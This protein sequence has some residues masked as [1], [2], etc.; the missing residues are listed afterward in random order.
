[1][2]GSLRIINKRYYVVLSYKSPVT[3]KWCTTTRSTGLNVKNNKK[4]ATAMIP[5]ILEQNRY[6]EAPL[7]IDLCHD[8][9]NI[10]QL[11]VAFNNS[12]FIMFDEYIDHWLSLKKHLA[13]ST[14]EKYSYNVK[15]L[16]K[17]WSNHNIALQ[18]ITSCEIDEFLQYL[19]LY[20]KDNIKTHTQEPLAPRTVRDYRTI[21][22]NIFNQ[23]ITEHL[24]QTNPVIEVPLNLST[25]EVDEKYLFL[26]S[27]EIKN[28][29]DFFRAELPTLYPF[30]FIGIFLGLRRS[31]ILGL[32]WSSIDFVEKKIKIKTTVTRVQTVHQNNSTKSTNSYRTLAMSHTVEN[33]LANIF[34]HQCEYRSFFKNSYKNTQD[35]VF[36]HPDGSF[37]NPDWFSK[38][39]NKGFKQLG[40]PEITFHKLRH[41]CASL[42][43][44]LN[45]DVKKVQY[46]LGHSDV[47]TTLKIYTHYERHRQNLN[48]EAIDKVI[49]TILN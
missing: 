26:S 12:D 49:E 31:E 39:I 9:T 7:N 41:T 44:E 34:K 28:A 14:Y 5:V 35:Y 20:G 32:K 25:T 45:W 16:H 2:T 42:L 43:I 17:Y 19:L 15:K 27:T 1:M 33:L 37:I 4:K 30:V 22:C 40:R 29:L 47:T 23:G 48:V 24:L 13:P 3:G 38:Q 21:L 6:L 46:W 11:P 10:N 18:N 36:T 8:G